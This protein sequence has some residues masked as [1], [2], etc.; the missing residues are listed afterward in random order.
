MKKKNK[1]NGINKT[2]EVL[3]RQ[4]IDESIEQLQKT[5]KRKLRMVDYN[6]PW[7]IKTATN[8]LWEVQSLFAYFDAEK[9]ENATD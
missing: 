2:T 5:R 7:P 8:V 3:I 9:N 6:Y 1:N 4:M